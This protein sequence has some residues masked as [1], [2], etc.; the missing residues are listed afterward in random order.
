MS[1]SDVSGR[2]A[3][4]LTLINRQQPNKDVEQI[5][6]LADEL[7]VDR[8]IVGMP[9]SMSGRSSNQTLKVQAFINLLKKH[10]KVPIDPCDERLST[11]EAQQLLK[12]TGHSPA[13]MKNKLDAASAT[14]ILQRYLDTSPQFR[15]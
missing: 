12:D 8:V 6:K 10:S 5:L 3:S 1:I 11:W 14:I 7:S 2:L 4:P 9:L 13:E 15:D